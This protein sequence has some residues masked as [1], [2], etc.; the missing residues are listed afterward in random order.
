MKR[1]PGWGI[2]KNP[3]NEYAIQKLAKQG[4]QPRCS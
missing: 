3:A 1:I 2:H 4:L